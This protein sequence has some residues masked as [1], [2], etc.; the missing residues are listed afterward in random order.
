MIIKEVMESVTGLG[1]AELLDKYIIK[2]YH[3]TGTYLIVPKEKYHLITGTPN[4]M[5]GHIN[6]MGANAMGGY[7]GHAGIFST[8]DD[9]LEFLID[10]HKSDIAKDAYT[11]GKLNS[12]IGRMGN[13]YVS[14]PLGLEKSFVDTLEP[15]DS[16]AIQGSTRVN[17]TG[18]SSSSHNILFNPSSMSIEEA[19]YRV[20]KINEERLKEGMKPIDPIHEFELLRNGELIKYNLIDPRQLLPLSSM[21][22]VIKRNAITILKLRFFNEVLKRYSNEHDKTINFTR[23]K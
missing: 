11:K 1:F 12:A 7:S 14:H 18:S 2:P 6:D 20:A 3:L 8:S 21:T 23:N 4:F 22:K 19:K 13:V 9:L 5:I 15:S 10:I 16:I 17:A